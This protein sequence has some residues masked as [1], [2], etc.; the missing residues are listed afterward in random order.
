MRTLIDVPD[1]DIKWLDRVAA[2]RGKSRASLVREAIS[3]F[4]AEAGRDWIARGAGYWKD[5]H[6]IGD[7]I[8]YQRAMRQDR[9]DGR[10]A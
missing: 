1:D 10:S 5:R 4:R 2:E 7:A 8:D 6:D 9:D 3:A